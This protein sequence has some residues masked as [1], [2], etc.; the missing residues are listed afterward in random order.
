MGSDEQAEAHPRIL[1][2][3]DDYLIA[4]EMKI[5]LSDAGFDVAGVA[6]SA[7]EAVELAE[8][9]NPDLAV[10]DVRLGGDRDGIDAAV[11]IFRKLGIR[12]IF[13]TAY[14]DQH[15]VERARPAMPIGW[16]QKPYSKASL[17]NAVH[18]ALNELDG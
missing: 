18:R 9:L 3:E 6:A 10:I 5:T 12:C 4:T 13:A 17:L 7:D 1:V 8:S 16:L 15:S 14:F 2:V 11:E